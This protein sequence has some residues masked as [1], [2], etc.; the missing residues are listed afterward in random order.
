MSTGIEFL[1]IDELRDMAVASE[2]G[3]VHYPEHKPA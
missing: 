1:T 2:V 3:K